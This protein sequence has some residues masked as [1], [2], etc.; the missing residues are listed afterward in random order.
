MYRPRGAQGA[1]NRGVIVAISFI[2]PGNY[3][4]QSVVFRTPLVNKH[5]QVLSENAGY[6]RILASASRDA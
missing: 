6:M 3:G 2:H 4:C 5:L 1:S